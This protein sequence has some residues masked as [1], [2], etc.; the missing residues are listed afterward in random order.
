VRSEDDTNGDGR[1]DKWDIY[2][3]GV[4]REVRF[5]TRLTS[6]RADRRLLYDD[7][8]LL[9][10]IEVDDNGD[11]V[12]ERVLVEPTASGGRESNGGRR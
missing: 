5:D 11:G 10:R 6:G 2:R 12:F 9:T 4:L 7:H 3:D 8:G 1:P